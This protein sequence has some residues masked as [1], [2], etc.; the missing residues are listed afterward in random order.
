VERVNWRIRLNGEFDDLTVLHWPPLYCFVARLPIA[1]GQILTTIARGEGIPR[2]SIMHPAMTDLGLL[3]L[4][5]SQHALLAV[6]LL[7]AC[8]SA[9]ELSVMRFLIAGLFVLNPALYAFAH[10]VG[11]EAVSNAFTLLIA[12]LAYRFIVTRTAS[13]TWIRVFFLALVIAILTRHV[14]AILAGLLPGAFLLALLLYTIGKLVCGDRIRS[15]EEVLLRN[16][17]FTF[18]LLGAGALVASNAVTLLACRLTKT[19]FRSK[20]GATFEWR[21]DYLETISPASQDKILNTIE[22]DLNDPAIFYAFDKAKAF[23]ATGRPWDPTII[24]SALF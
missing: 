21:L 7:F 6:T 1:L 17:I 18:A 3:L 24:H 10:S 20:I 23:L 2:I 8:L 5:I 14:N 19:P 12:I 22:R 13:K 9:S 16:R 15:C 11:S 4:L